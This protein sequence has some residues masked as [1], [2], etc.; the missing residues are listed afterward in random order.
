MVGR[1]SGAV[2]DNKKVL[3]SVA[4]GFMDIGIVRERRMNGVSSVRDNFL[5]LQS[6]RMAGGVDGHIRWNRNEMRQRRG[7]FFGF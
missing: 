7:H 6:R 3:I 2:S 1:G 4:K 5:Q